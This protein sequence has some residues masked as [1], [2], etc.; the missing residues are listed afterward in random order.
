MNFDEFK[1]KFIKD[2]SILNNDI[3][4]SDDVLKNFYDYMNGIISW[5]DKI[6]VTAIVDPDEFIVK[7]FIDSITINEIVE[8]KGKL[9]DIGTGAGFPG[10]PIKLLNDKLSV[11]LIDAVNK[12]LNVIR[13]VS[14]DMNIDNLEIIHSRAE[15]LARDKD[16][17]E[18][19]DYVTTR[20]VSNLSTILE[21]MI[22]FLKVNGIAIC[23]KGPN[24]KEE[25]EEA[26]NTFKLLGIKLKEVKKYVFEGQE[27]NVLIIEKLKKTDEKF[28]RGGGKPLK[29]PLK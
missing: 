28:P 12:K 5:N 24:Y 21:Y 2:L 7:H 11:T 29:E 17:R 4:L 6:N 14:K 1:D 20:A 18:Q 9:L 27:R 22:P 26:K 16:Y 8:N 3:N 13:D 19:Y 10:V 15:D 23:M 25:I